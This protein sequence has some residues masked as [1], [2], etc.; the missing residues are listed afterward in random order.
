MPTAASEDEQLDRRRWRLSPADVDQFRAD[1]YVLFHRQVFEPAALGELYEIFQEHLADKGDKLSDELDTPHY[2]DPRLLKFLLSDPVLDL[3]EPII[4][5]DIALWS[6]HFIVKDARTGRATPWHEDSGVW[7]G[8]L[9]DYTKIV[10]VWLALDPV[11]EGNGCVRVVA[12]SH[13]GGGF[14]NYHRVDKSV[15]TFASEISDEIDESKVVPFEIGPGEASLHDARI[16]H[17]ATPNSSA[18]RRAGYTMRY[19]STQSRL[20]PR[21]DEDLRIWLARGVDRAGN[22]YENA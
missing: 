8:L 7:K 10:T 19:L 2:R 3:V 21:A 1:G 13:H 4:G 18:V 11:W 15:N 14:S 6:S 9:D 12:G 16:I 20:T 22:T 17:G 5:P